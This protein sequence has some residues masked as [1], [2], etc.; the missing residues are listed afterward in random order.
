[1]GRTPPTPKPKNGADSRPAPF[2]TPEEIAERLQLPVQK[3]KHMLIYGK[4]KTCK[5]ICVGRAIRIRRESFKE[6]AAQRL[7]FLQ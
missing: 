3:V 5:F 6:W 7:L 2:M 1:V 4:M